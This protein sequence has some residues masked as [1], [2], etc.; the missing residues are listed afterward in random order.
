MSPIVFSPRRFSD[1]RGWFSETWSAKKLSDH[2]VDVEFCQDN[3][4]YS[5]P[6]GTLRGLHFQAPPFVQAKLVRCLVGRI[7]DVAVDVRKAS[8]TYGRWVGVELSAENGKQLFVPSGYAHAFLTLETDCEVAYKVDNPYA[9]QCDGGLAW[10]DETIGI[11]WPLTN[12]QPVLSDKDSALP[13]LGSMDIEFAYDG[14]P[15]QDLKEVI[16]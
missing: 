11:D 6:K 7:F 5:K 14:L 2:G 4:S 8:P 3:H 16:V 9:P 13:A 1:S 10:N 12:L 15:M